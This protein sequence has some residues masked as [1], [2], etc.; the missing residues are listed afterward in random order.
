[1]C[2]TSRAY[3]ATFQGSLNCR[4]LMKFLTKRTW[5]K[6]PWIKESSRNGLNHEYGMEIIHG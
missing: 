5:F 3:Y 2:I 1:L 4:N 6:L